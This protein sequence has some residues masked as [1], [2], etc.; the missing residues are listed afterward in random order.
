MDAGLK[1]K[2]ALVTGGSRGIGLAIAKCFAA[3]GVKVVITGRSADALGDA[4]AD[5]QRGG[6]EVETVQ[7]D[8]LDPAH[9]NAAVSAA[10]QRFGTVHIL[11]NNAGGAGKLLDFDQLTDDDWNWAIEFNLMSAVRAVR[12]VL[13]VMRKQRW[14]QIINISSESAQQPDPAI[15]HYNASK[16]ALSNFSKS[17]SKALAVD[18]IRVNTVSPAAVRS[19]QLSG[20]VENMAVER[21]IS[22]SAAETSILT[23]MRPNIVLKRFGTPEEVAAAVVFLASAGASFITGSDLRVDG[24][25]VASV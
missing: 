9:A 17:M 16:A 12:A 2:V 21:G 15:Q 19:P 23:E 13:P 3:E 14:G 6:G 11:V 25:S 5:I 1:E 7:G 20:V 22:T 8:V 4:A 10:V 18:G 24:G